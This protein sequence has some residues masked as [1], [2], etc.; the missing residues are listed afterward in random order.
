MQRRLRFRAHR[1]R[2]RLVR[3]SALVIEVLIGLVA[4]LLVICGFLFWRLVEGPL[5]LDFL[6][7]VLVEAFDAQDQAG[8]SA[9]ITGTWLF[10][11]DKRQSLEL[12]VTDLTVDD[13]TG[14]RSFALPLANID[15]SFGRLLEG[16]VEVTDIEMIGAR[17]TVRRNADQG[18]EV[19]LFQPSGSSPPPQSISRRTPETGSREAILTEPGKAEQAEGEVVMTAIDALLS[20]K[21]LGPIKDLRTVSLKNSKIIVDDRVLGF[22]WVLPANN[23]ILQRSQTGLSGKIAVGLPFGADRAEV[24]LAFEFDKA[25]GVLDIAGQIEG[26]DL[27]ALAKFLPQVHGLTVL[28][29]VLNGDVSATLGEGGKIFFVD[30]E[31]TAGPG[32]LRPAFDALPPVTISGGAISGRIDLAA[33]SLSIYDA[34]LQTGSKEAPGPE[35]ASTLELRAEGKGVWDLKA[36]AQAS[37][38]SVAQLD[39]LWPAVYGANAHAWVV[40]N[41]TNGMVSNLSAVVD[42]RLSGEGAEY[43]TLSGSFD[44]QDLTLYYLR[45]MPPMTGLSGTIKVTGD[46]M[47]FDVEK[48]QSEGLALGPGT[49]TIYDLAQDLPKILIEIP[50]AGS[51]AYMLA[52]LDQPRLALMSKAGID[53]KGAKGQGR[54]DVTMGF[55]LLSDLDA[56]DMSLTAKGRFKNV[57]MR[58]A[59][60]GQD[61]ASPSLALTS[62]LQRLTIKGDA[63]IAGSRI[64]TSYVQDYD[65]RLELEGHGGAIKAQTLI[66]LVPDLAKILGGDLAGSF[67]IKG[68]P[69][70]NLTIDADVDLTRTSLRPQLA[71]WSKGVGTPGRASGEVVL[72]GGDLQSI[73]HLKLSAPGLDAAGDITFTDGSRLKTARLS[74]VK[75]REFDLTDLRMTQ[76]TES[77]QVSVGGGTIDVRPWISQDHNPVDKANTSL[78]KADAPPKTVVT[79]TNLQRVILP[80][81]DL[82]NV[83]ATIDNSQ[84]IFYIDLTGTLYVG[85]RVEG[86]VAIAFQSKQGSGRR[87][88]LTIADAGS[89]LRAL[90]AGDYVEGGTLSWRGQTP[91]GQPEAL[92][93]GTLSVGA[94]KVKEVP[95]AL[96]VIMVAGLT[97][98]EDALSGPGVSF[99]KLTG[100]LSIKGD[101]FSSKQ[102]RA[103]GLALGI[104]ASG[105]VDISEDRIDIEGKVVPAY[106]INSF[107]D[108]IPVLGWV[109]TGGEDQ[110]LFA[111]SYDVEGSLKEPRITINPISAL[112]PPVLRSLV[113]AITDGDDSDRRPSNIE[114]P[115]GS[116]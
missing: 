89:M 64:E 18:F 6:T 17:L 114:E 46:R 3:I 95:P 70:G 62:T 48:G 33:S 29:S 108:K 35:I 63:E 106:A 13:A 78:R 52:V 4:L 110:G 107:L 1:P 47:V 69:Y 71:E 56:G 83:T 102:L 53:R 59:V 113:E 96:K 91:P 76:Q 57:L 81:G 88:S 72:N 36:T 38:L 8:A 77:L 37:G 99:D 116:Q 101:R 26:V 32:Q 44:F 61:I 90:G 2:S 41:I 10:W 94:F 82:R 14:A 67:T 111:V 28:E 97:G 40:E 109:I 16:K 93:A 50:V 58:R 60:L 21:G 23:I 87:G 105:T 5:S 86:Q 9:Q 84:K 68:N 25:S 49:V 66:A 115:E 39:W 27:A 75:Y 24:D 65:G 80:D 55:P 22:H 54:L 51:L 43:E 45:P 104:F 112:T 30:F 34:R 100:D 92:L 73:D 19:L 15:F 103:I 42:L 79:L 74:H 11:D 12:Q 85:G 7:P 20:G 98:I 31:L